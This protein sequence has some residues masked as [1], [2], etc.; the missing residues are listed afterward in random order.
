M[1]LPLNNLPRDS[2]PWGREIESKISTLERTA[3]KNESNLASTSRQ[4]DSLA[5]NQGFAIPSILTLPNPVSVT[6]LTAP[7]ADALAGEY[8]FKINTQ[9][10]ILTL[11]YS[12]IL[13]VAD[14]PDDIAYIYAEFYDSSGN[15]LSQYG[16]ESQV[17]TFPIPNFYTVGSLT[18]YLPVKPD[19]YR[20]KL[21]YSTDG[22]T[23]GKVV[24]FK[25]TFAL[26]QPI[27]NT[28]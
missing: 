27:P 5:Q 6:Q 19:T 15:L 13:N 7:A 25:N 23:A 21:Y 24:T 16:E 8:V 10:F 2:Q 14:A 26:I 3:N 12:C 4:V 22:T 1:T 18:M 17:I 9:G 28:Q 11:G 20:M